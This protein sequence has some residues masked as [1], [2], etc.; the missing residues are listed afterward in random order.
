[1]QR[2][3]VL[4][5]LRAIAIL[6][7]ILSHANL[8]H[9]V[10]GG[11]GVTI[12]FFLSGYLIS[13]LLRVEFEKNGWINFKAFYLRRTVRIIPPLVICYGFV[14]LLMASGIFVRPINWSGVWWDVAFLTNYAPLTE[15]SGVPILLWSLNVEEHFY[16]VFPVIFFLILGRPAQT[17]ALVI[18]GLI[19]LVLLFRYLEFARGNGEMILH[20]THTRFDAILFGVLLTIDQA[21]GRK[22]GNTL[23]WLVFALALLLFAF[24]YRDEYFRAT[25]RY[26]IQG[27]GL[28][29]VFKVLIEGN[30][31][32][33]QMPLR[34]YPMK[35][36]A[37]WSYVLYLIHLP[38]VMLVGQKF[39][40][41][42]APLS[43]A[44]GIVLSVAFALLMERY[45]EKPL[46][47]WRRRIEGGLQPTGALRPKGV[48]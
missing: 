6:I 17:Q 19:A 25:I 48:E 35:R 30:L 29:F 40:G 18:G 3:E 46:Y 34:S 38:L 24:V 39:A 22:W 23:P 16:I 44:I 28:F 27:V 26:T 9:I 2:L 41:F 4:D 12:F 20:W 36:I 45:V 13:T 15:R 42:P 21:R 43:F 5:G 10:P 37:D 1:M 33:L 14:L 31:R 32:L 11:F 8:G 7:V 47:R